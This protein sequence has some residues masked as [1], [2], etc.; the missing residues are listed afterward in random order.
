MLPVT[1]KKPMSR[2]CPQIATKFSYGLFYSVLKR[3]GECRQGASSAQIL[4]WIDQSGPQ[5]PLVEALG[6][7]GPGKCL[8]PLDCEN[9]WP[10]AARITVSQISSSSS[11]LALACEDGVLILW[12]LAEGEFPISP[13]D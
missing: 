4:R 13:P 3:S 5:I 1:C 9:V 8:F 10:C 11:Y 12:N 7:A 6:G 2:T